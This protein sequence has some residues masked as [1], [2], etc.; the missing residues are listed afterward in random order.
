MGTVE[1][2]GKAAVYLGFAVLAIRFATATGS[3]SSAGQQRATSGVFALPGGRLVVGAA[4]LVVAGVGVR[5]WVTG[6]REDFL[7]EVD[8]DGVPASRRR[9]VRW[10]GRVGFPAKGTALVV[11]GGLFGWAAARFDASKAT[12]LDGA[13]HTIV[14]APFGRILLTV[15]ALGIGAF[16]LFSL[17]RARYPSRT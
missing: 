14:E 8:T 6:L 5:Q 16:G 17:L 7:E 12:G 2:L 15:V 4:A 3:P 10:L 9:V 13:V 11:V 1:S